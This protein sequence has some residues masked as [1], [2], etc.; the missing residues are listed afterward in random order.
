MSNRKSRLRGIVAVADNQEQAVE[1]FTAIASG[2]YRVLE[3][4]DGEYA[5]AT[6]NSDMQLL[7]PL[8]GEEMVAV[9]DD[10]K[11]EMVA[12]A[13]NQEEDMDAFYQACS[14]GCGAHVITDSLE[15]LDK[16]PACASDLPQMEDA[17]LKKNNQPKELLIAVATD[18]VSAVEA[19][20][21]LASGEGETFAAKCDDVMVVSNQPI[22]FDIYKNIP[23]ETVEGYV[24]QLAVASSATEDGKMKVHYL[25][26]ATDSGQEMHIVA[27]NQSPIFCPVTNLGLVDPEDEMSAEQK[28]TA[29]ADFLSKASQSVE[30]EEEEDEEEEENEDEDDDE[31]FDEEEEEEEEEDENAEEDEDQNEDDDDDDLSLGLAASKGKKAKKK[32]GVKRKVKPEMATASAK[33]EAEQLAEQNAAVAN[34]ENN[35]EQQPAEVVAAP[36]AAAPA[37]AAEVQTPVEVTASYVSIASS[38]MKGKSVDVNYVGNVQG[39]PTWMAFHNGIPFAKAIASASENPATFADPALGRAFQAIAAEQGV[40]AALSQLRFEEIKPVLQI[41][42]VVAEQISAQVAEQGNVLAEA[43]ARDKSELA[44]RY[45][46][47]LA[48]AAHGINTGYFRDASNPI[49]TALASTLEAVGLSGAEEL[50]QRAFI[51]HSP[52]YHQSIL[53]KAAEIMRYDQVVQNQMATAVTQIEPKN[54]ATA[55]SLSMGRPVQRPAQQPENVVA[56]AS[57]QQQPQNDFKSKL[58]GLKL[59]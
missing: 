14:S 17:D 48:T 35:G 26:T 28:A 32:G 56:T 1:L 3:S 18:R 24:P 30:S 25:T 7:N 20:R 41:E 57:A 22:N 31:D 9:P 40:S 19:F 46:S 4:K 47:A 16:C 54:V 36:A 27:S 49:M 5:I 38:E 8:T 21:A 15:L 43:T 23:A 44:T 51:E 52:E 10:E 42:Q 6:A 2:D 12:V 34:A 29:S 11:H 45:E 55:S 33:T 58:T 13:S 59:F 37:A 50:L 53:A 39:E